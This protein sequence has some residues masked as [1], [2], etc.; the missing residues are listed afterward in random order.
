MW[1]SDAPKRKP[2]LPSYV[3]SRPDPTVILLASASP[4]RREL[5][6]A[7]GLPHEVDP[8]EVDERLLPGEAPA[9]Y[10][11]RIARLKAQAGTARHPERLV[12]AADTAVVLD[13][14]VF[15]K[16]VDAGDARR[17]I[18]A[19][20]GRSHEVL[21]GLAVRAGRRQLTHVER[22]TVWFEPLSPAAIDAYVRTGE[23]LGK[24]GAYAIQGLASR[25]VPRIEGSYTNVVGLPIAALVSLLAQLDWGRPEGPDGPEGPEGPDGPQ[26]PDGPREPHKVS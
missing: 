21:T 22:T 18:T 10:V 1:P 9:V 15:G 17:M 13:G 25:F 2:Q 8:V 11:E 5:L 23:P 3:N 6:E 19:L 14:A 16:P 4:R 24:A 12:V 20:A 26:G 7:A